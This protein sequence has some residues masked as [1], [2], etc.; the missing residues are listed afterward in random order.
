[1]EK[2]K[3]QSI[4]SQFKIYKLKSGTSRYMLS[5]YHSGK[6][7]RKFFKTLDDAKAARVDL[8]KKVSSEG[9]AGLMFDAEARADYF[10]ARRLLEP[11]G[12]SVADAARLYVKLKAD[13]AGA[14]AW[15]DAV[16]SLL[17]SL[18]RLNRRPRTIDST[19]QRLSVF[20][21]DMQVESLADFT[22]EMV[23]GF[24]RMPYAPRTKQ[25]IRAALSALGNHCKRRGW[26]KENPIANVATVAVDRKR[27][28]IVPPDEVNKVF[29]AAAQIPPYDPGR[30]VRRLCLMWLA[31]LRR[32]EIDALQ[33]S[34]I[35]AN[36][37]RVNAGKLRGRR[38]VRFVQMSD[39]FRAWWDAFPG[40]IR[41]R[42]FRRVYDAAQTLAGVD[43][44]GPD[45][46][47]HTW[48]SCKLAVSENENET[49]RE[50]GNSPAVIYAHYWDYVS[51][52]EAESLGAY[53]VLTDPQ[54][55][56]S[57]VFVGIV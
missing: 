28:L 25:S 16:F 30:I 21:R 1:M 24:F 33:D 29:A 35:S 11:L 8:A 10:T 57:M 47:R 39:A 13:K 17:E 31:G 7:L 51:K 42:N 32:T 37:V 40:E 14:V 19:K 54:K 12:V 27:P 6:R 2:Q 34:D 15:V 3:N 43:L 49:A 38:S 22:P 45:V 18:E 56:K 36:G 26:L 20:A 52:Q 46:A 44:S 48:I 23:E 9:A 41:P 50:A 5:W 55:L 53:S 4:Q